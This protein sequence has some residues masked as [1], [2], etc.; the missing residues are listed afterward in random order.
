MLWQ[1]SREILPRPRGSKSSPCD[2]LIVQA[3]GRSSFRAHMQLQNDHHALAF[4]S[5]RLTSAMTMRAAEVSR[6]AASR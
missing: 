4:Y 2:R 5:A 6:R 3:V 1:C